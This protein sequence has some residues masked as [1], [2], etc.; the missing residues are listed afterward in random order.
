[1]D[2]KVLKELVKTRNV[3]KKKFRSIKIG[4][5]DTHEQFKDTFK[6]IIEPLTEFVNSSKN[7]KRSIK[8]E[9]GELKTKIFK[10]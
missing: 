6:P 8:A 9:S 5:A 2:E 1:M 10:N 4:E 7:K 3:L